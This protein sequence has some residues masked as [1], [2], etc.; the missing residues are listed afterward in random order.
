MLRNYPELLFK[1]GLT[2]DPAGNSI[3]GSAYQIF[4]GTQDVW[5]LK[6]IYEEIIPLIKDGEAKALEQYIQQFPNPS[7]ILAVFTPEDI[8]VLK[9]LVVEMQEDLQLKIQSISHQDDK[10]KSVFFEKNE[11]SVIHQLLS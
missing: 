2:R 8:V 11:F 7:C 5:A 9:S 3:Y 4:L 10:Y 6:T 1:Q